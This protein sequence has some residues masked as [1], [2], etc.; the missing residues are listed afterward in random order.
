MSWMFTA[1]LFLHWNSCMQY[2]I[3][4]ATG[5][6]DGCWVEVLGKPMSNALGYILQHGPVPR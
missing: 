2:L 1:I 6:P 3:A 5:Y 4:A